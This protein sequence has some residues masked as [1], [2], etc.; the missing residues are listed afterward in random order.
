MKTK[1]L[2]RGEADA[3]WSVGTPEYQV[4]FWTHLTD[5]LPDT[6]PELVGYKQD[7]YL[8]TDAKDV[9][10]VIAWAEREA[11]G[12]IVV[13][14]ALLVDRDGRRGLVHLSGDDPTRSDWPLG[15]PGEARHL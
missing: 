14:Y 5:R 8:V 13:I 7:S 9:G 3:T 11:Q 15:A 12:R 6:P 1:Y 4:D 2:E 10:E